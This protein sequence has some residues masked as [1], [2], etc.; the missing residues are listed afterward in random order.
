MTTPSI[1]YDQERIELM[2]SKAELSATLLEQGLV[3]SDWIYDNIITLVKTNMM[4][5]EI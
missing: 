5:I 1:I 2:K 3:P 4:N